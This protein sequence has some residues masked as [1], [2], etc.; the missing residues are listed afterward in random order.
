MAEHEKPVPIPQPESDRYWEGLR[1]HEFW[2]RKCLDCDQ[3]YFYPRD[4]C[5]ICFS[6]HTDWIRASGKGSVYTYAIVHRAPHPGLIED[7]P[8]ITALVELDEGVLV[9]TNIVGVD[10]EPDKVTIGMPVEVV[11]EK[12]SE[13]ITLPKFTPA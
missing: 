2:L 12:I 13:E 1:R 5:P 3:A 7:V 11:F 9:P 8:Y 4:I 10:P 6:R